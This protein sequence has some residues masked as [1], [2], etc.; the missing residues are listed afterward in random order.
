M[1][2]IYLLDSFTPSL[3]TARPVFSLPH[4]DLN[5]LVGALP[6]FEQRLRLLRRVLYK[7]LLGF[8]RGF[9]QAD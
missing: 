1:N 3:Y 5:A 8:R 9:M 6:L 4:A 7:V 2:V